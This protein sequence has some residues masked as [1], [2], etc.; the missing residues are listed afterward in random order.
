[1]QIIRFDFNPMMAE[2]A[3]E[4]GITR[5]PRSRSWLGAMRDA[6]RHGRGEPRQGHAGLDD[7]CPTSR[8][9][10]SP[11]SKRPPREVREQF[12]AFVVLGIG[13]S[14]LRPHRRAAGT[15]PPAL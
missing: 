2:Y 4:H 9:T 5:A 12:D 8:T 6:L 15:E 10:C 3:G 11:P 14:A 7:C 13:G 1:M